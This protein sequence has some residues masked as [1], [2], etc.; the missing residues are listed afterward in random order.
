MNWKGCGKNR[1]QPIQGTLSLEELT[2]GRP[3]AASEDI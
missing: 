2:K 1:S 3:V